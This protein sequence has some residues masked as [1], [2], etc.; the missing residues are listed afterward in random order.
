MKIG[1]PAETR[2]GET[3]VA[4]TPETVKKLVAGGH[5]VIVQSGAGLTSS[6]T[7]EAYAAVGAT[8]AGAAEAFGAG[9][10][11]KVRAPS[12]DERTL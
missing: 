11:L 1:I 3:R 2:P 8:I 12:A 6:V 10:V 4:A 9:L 7:D 5:Q